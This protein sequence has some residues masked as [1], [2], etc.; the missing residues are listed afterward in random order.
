MKKYFLALLIIITSSSIAQIAPGQHYLGPSVG[1]SFLG[2]TFQLGANY[3]YGMKL[4]DIGTIGVGGIFRYWS[5]KE[6]FYTGRWNYV[7]VVMGAQSNY[8]FKLEN[9]KIEPWAGVVLALNT[10]SV[11]WQGTNVNYATPA[12]GGLWLGFQGG[13]RYWLNQKTALSARVSFGT[14]SYGGLEVGVDFKL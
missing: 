14:I 3:E 13:V 8:Y 1:L 9:E 4:S 5:Y 11:D 6:T 7:N 2:S 10:S 12:T